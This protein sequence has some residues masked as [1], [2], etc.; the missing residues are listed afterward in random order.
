MRIKKNEV[1]KYV[2]EAE[3][4]VRQKKYILAAEKSCSLALRASRLWKLEQ[5]NMTKK[6]PFLDL[7]T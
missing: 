4:P 6:G 5:N 2:F 1:K 3:K 7:K